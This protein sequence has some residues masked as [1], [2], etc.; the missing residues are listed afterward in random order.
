METTNRNL[1]PFGYDSRI[2]HLCVTD[3]ELRAHATGPVTFGEPVE[4]EGRMWKW[5]PIQRVWI[6]IANPEPAFDPCDDELATVTL[7]PAVTS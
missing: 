1:R 2:P 5:S 3:E 7:A 6:T 4:L